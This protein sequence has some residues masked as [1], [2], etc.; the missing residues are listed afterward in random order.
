MRLDE[1]R[2]TKDERL[3]HPERSEGS[4][5]ILSEVC[6]FI[7]DCPH[8]T[9]NDEGVG[10]PLVRTPNVGKGRLVYNDM[11]RVSEDVYNQRNFRAVP[12]EDDLIF[13][14]EAPAG[15]VALIRKGEKV[16]LGQRTVLLRPNKQKVD[17]SFLTY[18]LLAP[19]Q[20]YGL[21]GTANGATV[22]HVNMPTI[23]NLSIELP[24]IKV[25]R[26]L[27][28][29]LSAYDNLIENNQK[30]IKLLEE[31]AQRL[32]KQWFIDLRYPGHETTK[33]VDGLPERWRNVTLGDVYGKIESGSRPKGGIDSSIRDGVV[34]VGAENVIG[35]GQ[36]NY[37]S[38]K[39]V[40]HEFYENSK[41]GKV[42][43]RDI[44]VYKDGAY[45]GRTSL[46]Q[47]EFPRKVMMVNEHVFLLNA[48]NPL[49]Q[50]Y[51][52][53]TLNRQEYFDKMQKLNKNSAQPGINQ[54]ALKS[55]VIIWPE[56][57]LVKNFDNF[58]KPLVKKIFSLAKQNYELS[59]SRNRFLPKLMDGEICL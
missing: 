44:L 18:Y 17:P 14:R 46:F 7:V 38:E 21:T 16:C 41:R 59:Q 36:Y 49:Y 56:D 42:E 10:F 3:C 23:R 32:Y 19:K 47:D 58:V 30:Q 12:Q 20:Q 29:I 35:L 31:A 8:S 37:S 43:D 28:G 1:R 39:L 5:T 27:G 51:L 6:E 13:A 33:I 54:D 48:K 25:Q 22:A 57:H 34:S 2:E 11:H 24:D 9:A 15:N 50:Y 55:L 52:F 26:K 53:F 4:K 45:I 40:S